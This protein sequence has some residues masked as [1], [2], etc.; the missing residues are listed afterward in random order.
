L[1]D[2]SNEDG[3][4]Y[5]VVGESLVARCAL[6]A[7]IKVDDMEQ[8]RE[9]IFHTRCYVNNKVCSMIIN[10]ES[11]TNVTST[12]LVEK[13]SLPLLKHPRPYKLQWLNEWRG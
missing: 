9:N 2:A 8:H 1:V 3:V 4:K 5:T 7:Q 6:N 13:L 12:T 10:G 11:C